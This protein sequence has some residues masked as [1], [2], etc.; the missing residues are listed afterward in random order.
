[1]SVFPLNVDR[2]ARSPH[3]ELHGSSC[4]II[5]VLHL[6]ALSNL[7]LAQTVV[8]FAKDGIRV[9]DE[10]INNRDTAQLLMLSFTR[11]QM[12]MAVSGEAVHNWANADNS[13][14]LHLGENH[15]PFIPKLTIYFLK[16][17]TLH[18]HTIIAS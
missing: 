10:H 3:I 9:H 12:N 14:R 17:L 15:F 18:H 5:Q 13:Q 16:V 8:H 11:N 1:M 7:D 2:I 6:A 4:R